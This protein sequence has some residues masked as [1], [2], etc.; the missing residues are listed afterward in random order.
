VNGTAVLE[1]NSGSKNIGHQGH[2]LNLG[3]RAFCAKV[4]SLRKKILLP[5]LHIKLGVMKQF[6]KALPKTGNCFQYLCK[7]FLHLAEAKLKEDVFVGPDIRKLIF[8]EDFLI[9]MTEVERE[10]WIAFKSVVIK[11]LGNNKI[12]DYVTIVVNMLEKFSLGVL[13][14]LKNSFFE[15]ALG[16]FS[17]KSWCSE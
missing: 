15:F 14:E 3:A 4:L 13:N 1:V 17:Q 11:F 5:R 7:R 9:K 16:F 2:I 12:P 6:F 8:S 10:A